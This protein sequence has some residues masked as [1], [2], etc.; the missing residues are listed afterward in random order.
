MGERLQK[1]VES[2]ISIS[3]EAVLEGLS[4]DFDCPQ[5]RDLLERVRMASQGG[6]SYNQVFVLSAN[7]IQDTIRSMIEQ[8]IRKAPTRLSAIMTAGLFTPV[9]FLVLAPILGMLAGN[10]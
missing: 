6:V 1:H 3:P 4:G 10:I 2:R 5:L 9:L 7:E 8:Q